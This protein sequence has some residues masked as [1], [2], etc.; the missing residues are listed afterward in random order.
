MIQDDDLKYW[1]ALSFVKDIGPV[2]IKKLLSAFKSP[3]R[4]FEVGFNELKDIEEISEARA[5]KISE[6]NSWKRV[7]KELDLIK[8]HKV[9]IIKYTD[10]DYPESLRNIND[11]PVMLYLKGDFKEQDRCAIAIVGSRNMSEYGAKIAEKLSHE[12]ASCGITIVSGMARGIDTVSH[13]GALK[14]GGRSIAILG[15]GLDRSYPPENIKLF[16]AISVS[17]CIISEFPMGTPPY[18]ENFPKRNRLISGISLG[19]IVVEATINSGSLITAYHALEQG[20]EVFAVP[21]SIFSKTS[22]GTN[23]LIKKGAKLVQKAEDILEELPFSLKGY[24]RTFNKKSIANL[25]KLEINDEEKAL[26]NILENEPLH[27]DVIARKAKIQHAKLLHL[28]LNLEIKGVVKQSEGNRY[29][30]C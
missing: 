10:K 2:T 9:K 17:G 12:L 29:S 28:L 24:L 30:L 8:R 25:D 1:L 13:R 5:K 21:G 20:K 14:S 6:F 18:K 15:C 7:E 26:C 16:E 22:E 3:K 19:V 11:S 4:I 27:I 23:E